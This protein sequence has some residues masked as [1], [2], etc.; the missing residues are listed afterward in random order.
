MGSDNQGEMAVIRIGVIV[1]VG[2]LFGI[3]AYKGWLDDIGR[4]VGGWLSF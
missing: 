2:T 3:A 1:L 4:V